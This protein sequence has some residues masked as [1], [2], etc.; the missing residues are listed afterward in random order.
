MQLQTFPAT[1]VLRAAV[2]LSVGAFRVLTVRKKSFDMMTIHLSRY[3][4]RDR[5]TTVS[6]IGIKRSVALVFQFTYRLGL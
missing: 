2:L 3:R 1:T 4:A 5:A 6:Q